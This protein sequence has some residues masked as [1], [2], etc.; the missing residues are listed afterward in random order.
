M[1]REPM[2]G[3]M[4]TTEFTVFRCG[5]TA[6][7]CP[8][9]GNSEDKSQEFG[10]NP[11]AGGANNPLDLPCGPL[12]GTR[13]R[14]IGTGEMVGTAVYNTTDSIGYTF[15]SYGN[16]SKLAGNVDYGY[17]TLGEVDPIQTSYT[18]GELPVCV[19][20][21]G[22]SGVCPATPGASFPNLRSGAYKSWSVLRVVTNAS[23]INLTNTKALV[24]AIQDNVNSTVPDF[25]P[26]N[27]VG[28]DPGLQL[29]RSHY[30][31]SGVAPNNGLSG[32]KEAG[33]DMGGCIENKGPAP[34]IL[35]C[36]Q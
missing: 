32:E 28:A 16:V 33:G 24:T 14:A 4:N 12:A 17:L 34:G 19:S 15:F 1:Q 5:N 25:V 27:A 10:V 31:Q 36:H 20:S 30:L 7:G 18:N 29:Y 22:V 13:Q 35:S 23:G 26:F 21:T 3:T 11:P 6:G 8:I 9:T 2:S